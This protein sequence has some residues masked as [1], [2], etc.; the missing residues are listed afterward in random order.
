MIAVG[1]M[2][3]KEYLELCVHVDI[4][5]CTDRHAHIAQSRRTI[6]LRCGQSTNTKLFRNKVFN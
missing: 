6:T 1:S 2:V 5:M 3:V 4:Y